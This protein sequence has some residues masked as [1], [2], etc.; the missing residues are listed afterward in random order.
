MITPRETLLL[1]APSLAAFQRAIAARVADAR[2]GL[3]GGEPAVLV[4]TRAAADQL[5]RTLRE[6]G[7]DAGGGVRRPAIVPRSEWYDWLQARAASPVRLLTQ[8]EREVLGSLAG[9]DAAAAGAP[10]PFRLRPGIVAAL[11]AFYDDLRRRQKTVDTFERLLIE[12]LEPSADIDRGARRLLEQTRFLIAAFR[13]YEQRLDAAPGIDEHRLRDHLRE[14]GTREP[15]PEV[16]VTVPDEV[17]NP[18]GLYP[19][20]FDLLARLPGLARVTIV[21]TDSLLDS[22]F[23]QRLD[24]VLPEIGEVRV[25]PDPAPPPRLV[26]PG[27]TAGAAAYFTYRD[28][29]EELRGVARAVSGARVGAPGL[30]AAVVVAR[31]LPYL[32]LAPP[33]FT[34]ADLRTRAGDGLPLAVEPYAAA[35]HL[36]LQYAAGDRSATTMS[37]FRNPHFA[38]AGDEAAGIAGQELAPLA[39]SR[40]LAHHLA[41]LR[42]FLQRHAAPLP[43]PRDA[44]AERTARARALI[45]DGLEALE[46]AHRALNASGAGVSLAEVAT[47][48]RR[49]IESRTYPPDRSVP[50]DGDVHL[51]DPD[52]APYGRFDHLFIAGLIEAEWPRRAERNIF[53][54]VGMLASLGWPVERGRLR[55]VRALFNDLLRL[56]RARVQLSAF[57]LEDDTAVTVSPMLED[58]DPGAVDRIA[59]PATKEEDIQAPPD[60][61]AAAERWRAFRL[62]RAATG[63]AR[64]RLR[65]DIG[66]QPSRPYAVGALERYLD[67]P[68]KYFARH[69][70]RLK[71]EDDEEQTMTAE[72][73]GRFLH[74]VFETFFK[75]W[76]AEGHGA[77]TLDTLDDALA[78]FARVAEARLAALPP[79]E[80][81]VARAWLL[82][83]PASSG[84]AERVFSR[85]AQNPS[86]DIVERLLE[87]PIDGEF[88]LG[89]S[90]SRRTIS[91]RGR[92]DR[93]DLHADGT[94]VVIDY[95]TGRAPERSR[96]LQLPLYAR[97]AEQR[98]RGYRGRDWRAAGGMYVAFGEPRLTVPMEGRGSAGDAMAEGEARAVSAVAGIEAG[99][100][101]PRPADLYRCTMCPYQTVCRK[102]YVEDL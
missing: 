14:T 95:K 86:S 43:D 22:G 98:L 65:G 87:H 21:A 39:E 74:Q 76:G 42:A 36:V 7:A 18:A 30:S 46:I 57:L 90:P 11:L 52:T 85:E 91:L 96:A 1:R 32:Y 19:A 77:I 79:A 55:A 2:L 28:R 15:V 37:L 78:R 23:R 25:A 27:D 68:F 92:P 54:P 3:E 41:T 82:G 44:I 88:E 83:S 6:L 73:R 20:D 69:V 94:L 10:P 33:I 56:P 63:T 31:P 66:P 48:V 13:A 72:E 93:I 38:F 8:V 53:Y 12:D 49:W 89:A 81:A 97:C 34:G 5:R 62:A 47:T 71:E 29:E 64:D 24:D 16:V 58:L 40:P 70:L 75:A 26:V 80:Q 61:A 50:R 59:A 60:A 45:H 67:C 102:D 4:P 99:Q 84:L 51:I 17:A 100:C 35:V 101:P 9:R